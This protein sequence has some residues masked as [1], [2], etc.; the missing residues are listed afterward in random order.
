[1]Q[2]ILLVAI[3]FQKSKKV[4]KDPI[5]AASSCTIM[6][7]CVN[8]GTSLALI[9]KNVYCKILILGTKYLIHV[10]LIHVQTVLWSK[11]EIFWI[12]GSNAVV[13]ILRVNEQGW[14]RLEKYLNIQDCLEKSLKIQF[15]M[16]STGKTL[17]FTVGINTVFGHLNQYKFVVSLFG[18]AY[19]APNKGTTILYLF[20]KQYYIIL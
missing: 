20:S 10:N 18:A 14:H 17:K 8:I 9:P 4:T 12:P 1:M 13:C 19:A 7:L 6:H 2:L 3:F 16:K 11:F 5:L 15:A